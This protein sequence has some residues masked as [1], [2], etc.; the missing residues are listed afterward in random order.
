[1]IFKRVKIR[2]CYD[3]TF[4]YGSQIQK[5]KSLPTVMGTFK[6][7]LLNLGINETPQS[8]G[9]TDR[10]VHALNQI[11]HL[12]VPNFFFDLQRLKKKLNNFLSPHIYIKDIEFT[13]AN[14]HARFDAKSRVYRY[15][16]SLSNYNPLLA[17]Y[18]TF[19]DKLDLNLINQGLK[20]FEGEHNFGFF[21]KQGANNR[22]DIRILYRSFAYQKGNFV[23]IYFRGNSFL[24]SQIRLICGFLF[25]L[26]KKRLTLNDLKKQ[27]DLE[28]RVTTALAPPNGLYLSKI[29]Y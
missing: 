24:R 23:I 7:A 18:C 12:N 11:C 6:K 22:S 17:N 1:L 28:T 14:F 9:R 3:G 4:F 5:G 21:K 16:V 25:E 20:I 2:F 27:L 8:S 10:G 29:Y 13:R 15:I 26:D 19:I